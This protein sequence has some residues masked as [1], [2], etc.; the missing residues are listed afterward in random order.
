MFGYAGEINFDPIF[1][2]GIGACAAGLLNNA[3]VP[4]SGRDRP[5]LD[6]AAKTVDPR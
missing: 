4:Q 2:I 5:R 6:D 3:G 1:L